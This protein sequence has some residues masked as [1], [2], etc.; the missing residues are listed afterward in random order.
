MLDTSASGGRLRTG[1]RG[2]QP[3]GS[4]YRI[5]VTNTLFVIICN[6]QI[7]VAHFQSALAGAGAERGG[8][9]PRALRATD[10]Q[11]VVDHYSICY[12]CS[13]IDSC[14]LKSASAE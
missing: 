7:E 8:L 6:G 12:N 10:A 13:G 3:G 5:V 11:Y 2:L 14:L 4:L 1:S 9:S